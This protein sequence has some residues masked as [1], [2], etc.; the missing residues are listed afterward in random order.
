MK[1]KIMRLSLALVLSI[2]AAAIMSGSPASAQTFISTFGDWNAF[3]DG[4]GRDKVCYIA[5]LPK[6]TAPSNVQRGKNYILISHRPGEKTRNVFEFRSGYP[7]KDG[8]EVDLSIDGNKP[9]K[10][11][12]KDD[13]AWARD[14][15]TDQ[16]IAEAMKKGRAVT[17]VGTSARGTKTTDTY[18][19]SGISAALGA[20]DKECK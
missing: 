7:F 18:S 12:T 1:R 10:L 20:I 11:F 3:H 17:I 6:S 16:Q 14:D 8:Q 5:S 2:P 15:T 4:S 19:L 9:I 13:A